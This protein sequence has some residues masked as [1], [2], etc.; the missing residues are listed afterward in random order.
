MLQAIANMPPVSQTIGSP[1]DKSDCP[2]DVDRGCD[3]IIETLA[4]ETSFEPFRQ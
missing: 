1:C 3:F 4:S 2:V